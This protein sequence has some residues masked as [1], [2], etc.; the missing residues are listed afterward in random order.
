MKDRYFISI[1]TIHGTKH[2]SVR[3]IIKHIVGAL[4]LL[5]V[6]TLA[7]GYFY[8]EFLSSKSEKLEKEKRALQHKSQE[9]AKELRALN[10]RLLEKKGEL[11]NLSSKIDDLETKLELKVEFYA[12]PADINSLSKEDEKLILTLVPSGNPVQKL[13]ISAPFGW[14]KHPI[15]KKR[16]FHPGI[17]ISGRGEI[18]VRATA[19]G[20]VTQARKSRYGYGNVVRID[21]VFGFKTLY[22]HL[23][24]IEVEKG[25]F[26]KKGDIIG[27]MGNSGLSTGQHLHYEVRYDSKPLNPYHFINWNQKDFNTIFQ[28]E[29]RVP[30]ESLVKAVTTIPSLRRLQS[31]PLE[32]KSSESSSSNQTSTSTEK[33]KAR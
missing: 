14:R 18:A 31:S 9:L 17:D 32:Q 19:N 28:K 30:W 2:Y 6:V 29:R 13:T 24:K 23:R 25:D 21:H 8:I 11:E 1:T 22:A 4:L 16:E 33:S 26:I 27:Y 15:L 20:I 3:Q 12:L 10:I 5:V 7:A